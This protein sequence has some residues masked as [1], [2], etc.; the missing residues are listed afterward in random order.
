MA[1]KGIEVEKMYYTGFWSQGDG[2]SF[3]GCIDDWLL[4]LR[5]AS[6]DKKYPATVEMWEKSRGPSGS[7]AFDFD[8]AYRVRCYGRYSHSGTMEGD[9]EFVPEHD[10]SYDEQRLQYEAAQALVNAALLEADDLETDCLEILRGHADTLYRRLEEEHEYQTDDEQVIESL[11][12]SDCLLELIEDIELENQDEDDGIEESAPAV[13][14]A[15]SADP[16]GPPQLQAVGE[17]CAAA[18]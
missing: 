3:D 12:S 9:F 13:L 5:Q 18:G 10:Y 8:L 2:A 15:G 17:E 7:S 1:E 11:I 14:P 4:F 6:L 16:S